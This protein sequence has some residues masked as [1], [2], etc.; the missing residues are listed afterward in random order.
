MQNVFKFHMN[1]NRT[2]REVLGAAIEALEAAVRML[3]AQRAA[4]AKRRKPKCKAAPAFAW[5]GSAKARGGGY[6]VPSRKPAP[7]RRDRRW[8]SP[9]DPEACDRLLSEAAEYIVANRI[10][11]R[12]ELRRRNNPLYMALY[13]RG[14]LPMI[15]E[16][17]GA[18]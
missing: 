8:G 13:H 5:D 2:L 12:G 6:K 9:A 11:S 7:G 1:G 14:L 16:R 3:D 17:I 4:E 18:R 15:S 10:M